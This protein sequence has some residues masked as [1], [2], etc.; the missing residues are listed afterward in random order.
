[1]TSRAHPDSRSRG[2]GFKIGDVFPADDPIARWATVVAMA[3]NNTIYLNIR[4]IEGDLP[5]ELDIYY[6]RLVAAHFYEAAEWLKKT[7]T[8]WPEIDD[9]IRSRDAES[10]ARYD[11]I[12]SFASQRH[13]LNERLRRSRM[14]LFHYPEM[15][16]NKEQAGIEELANALAHAKDLDGWI[17]GGQ[18]YAS[19]RAS[20]ADEVAVQF[21]AENEA[22][23]RELKGQLKDP[24]FQ[25]VEF[26]QAVLLAQ[27]KRAP[28]AATTIWREGEPKPTLT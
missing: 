9:L 26:A 12:V 4:M 19:F 16:P 25:L 17:E 7:R 15:H 2:I 3:A 10:Q 27:L 20:F 8:T 21:L 13:P 6:F 22:E 5:P 24:V 11:H 18:D 14:T 28:P 1:M 23:T